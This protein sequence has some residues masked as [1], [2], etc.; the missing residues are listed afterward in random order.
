MST[1]PLAALGCPALPITL[2]STAWK[3][4][5]VMRL[6]HLWVAYGWNS[7]SWSSAVHHRA[8]GALTLA[9]LVAVGWTRRERCAFRAQCKLLYCVTSASLLSRAVCTASLHVGG[10][11]NL[12]RLSER[13]LSLQA[14]YLCAQVWQLLPRCQQPPEDCRPASRLCGARSTWL[15]ANVAGLHGPLGRPPAAEVHPVWG[16]AAPHYHPS[17]KPLS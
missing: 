9:C 2:R 16:S 1:A 12:M 14:P 7:P 8:A 4:Q 5:S 13:L 15:Q 6:L 10:L 3:S 17:G 11:G